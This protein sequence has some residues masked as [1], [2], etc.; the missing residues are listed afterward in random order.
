M[1]FKCM[2]V[3]VLDGHSVTRL[4]K[5]YPMRYKAMDLS[6]FNGLIW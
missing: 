5:F 4:A 3:N 2:K 6:S 1:L